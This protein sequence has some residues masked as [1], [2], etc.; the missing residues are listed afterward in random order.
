M[1][2]IKAGLALTLVA[3]AVSANASADSNKLGIQGSYANSGDT[4][5]TVTFTDGSKETL[6]AG[7][8][9]SIGLYTILPL[10]N[11]GI[12]LKLAANYLTDAVLATNG[13]VRFTRLPLDAL[14]LNEVG[15]W[16]IA[17]GLTYHFKPQYESTF[18]SGEN[19]D[20]ESALGLILEANYEFYSKD[21]QSLSANIGGRYTNIEYSFNGVSKKYDGSNFALTV[22]V[23]F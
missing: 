3:G 14:I 15:K 10:S 21:D 13:E 19:I 2:I 4:L 5:A 12:A 17:A 16:Q 22:G 23:T 18:N 8:G 11:E 7:A 20:A 6:K 1:K 9:F